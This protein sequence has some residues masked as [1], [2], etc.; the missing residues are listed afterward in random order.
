ME[1]KLVCG[2]WSFCLLVSLILTPDC[3]LLLPPPD[4]QPLWCRHGP[5]G[6]EGDAE[7]RLHHTRPRRPLQG[8]V[9]HSSQRS[10]THIKTRTDRILSGH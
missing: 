4:E 7:R 3:R 1:F 2:W 8:R 5:A 9:E 10:E 6:G